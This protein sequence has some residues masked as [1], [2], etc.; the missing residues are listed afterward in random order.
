MVK[1]NRSQW[2]QRET[3]TQDSNAGR[4]TWQTLQCA[5]IAPRVGH[6]PASTDKGRKGDI[7]KAN[8]LSTLISSGKASLRMLRFTG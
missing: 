1:G 8:P 2:R 4:C 3:S 7:I 5:D 6:V